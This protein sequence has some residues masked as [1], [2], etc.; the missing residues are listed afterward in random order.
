MPQTSP[1]VVEDAQAFMRRVAALEIDICAHCQTGRLGL[2][3][4]LAPLR[5]TVP[6]TQQAM[7]VGGRHEGCWVRFEEPPAIPTW[8]WAAVSA[9]RR[10]HLW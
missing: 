8:Q 4:M 5:S 10:E 1:L 6:E 2:V 7:A 9:L 3:Q